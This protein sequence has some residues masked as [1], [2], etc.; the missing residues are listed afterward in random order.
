MKEVWILLLGAVAL[1]LVAGGCGGEGTEPSPTSSQK[2]R[3]SST[4][5]AAMSSQTVPQE[6]KAKPSEGSMP[7]SGP[8]TVSSELSSSEAGDSGAQV[9][10]ITVGGQTFLAELAENTAAN[11]L[12][13]M[14]PMTLGMGD[15]HGAAKSFSLPSAF[16]QEPEVYAEV[17]PGQLVLKDS[18]EVLLFYGEYPQG[19]S[20]TPLAVIEDPAGLEQALTG[21]LVEVTFQMGE[22]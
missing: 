16:S 17:N 5:S 9:L 6:S 19:G 14:L 11:S 13:E 8:E 4:L 3:T 15:W 10:E 18:G 22:S 20:F 7:S 2:E 1:L 12:E 21:Q